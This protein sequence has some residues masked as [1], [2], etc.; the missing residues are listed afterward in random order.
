MLGGVF[1]SNDVC[2]GGS[3][4]R[5]GA[6][7]GRM[8]LLRSS[9]PARPACYPRGGGGRAGLG[10][11]PLIRAG[12]RGPLNPSVG[13]GVVLGG[14][15]LTFHTTLAPRWGGGGWERSKGGALDN[16]RS[17]RELAGNFFGYCHITQ[18]LGRLPNIC[19]EFF[20]RIVLHV[21]SCLVLK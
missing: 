13:G 11:N 7:E 9:L 18:L 20:A 5:G 19:A 12:A 4:T 6:V 14:A 10:E 3:S 21:Q 8:Y 2:P 16:V 17:P 15:L 1:P